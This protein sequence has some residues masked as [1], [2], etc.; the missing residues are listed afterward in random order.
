VETNA[1]EAFARSSDGGVIE[2]GKTPPL[3]MFT[4][5]DVL[6]TIQ[7]DEEIFQVRRLTIRDL[8]FLRQFPNPEIVAIQFGI[9]YWDYERQW[10][11]FTAEDVLRLTLPKYSAMQNALVEQ[12]K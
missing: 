4:D 12:L 8:L 3:D 7:V 1:Q 6:K 11:S 9:R 10:V 5:F 2:Q